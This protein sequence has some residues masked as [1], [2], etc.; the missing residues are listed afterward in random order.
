MDEEFPDAEPQDMVPFDAY[1]ALAETLTARVQ[2]L[3][4]AVIILLAERSDLPALARQ[5]DDVLLRLDASRSKADGTTPQIMQANELGRL[6]AEALFAN[7]V[8]TRQ[9]R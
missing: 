2:A 5:A 3:E 7:G 6:A 4:A 1:A 8:R 9:R